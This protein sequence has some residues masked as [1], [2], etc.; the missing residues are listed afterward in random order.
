MQQL[1]H[2]VMA[3]ACAHALTFRLPAT[4]SVF[5]MPKLD[6]QAE[7]AAHLLSLQSLTICSPSYTGRPCLLDGKTISHVLDFVRHSACCLFTE[8]SCCAHRISFSETPVT[9]RGA[10]ITCPDRMEQSASHHLGSAAVKAAVV[11]H[12]IMEKSCDC[13]EIQLRTFS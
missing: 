3:C 5:D 1:C 10:Y 4:R 7:P 6:T 9:G 8:L 11:R 2:R 12:V 13:T